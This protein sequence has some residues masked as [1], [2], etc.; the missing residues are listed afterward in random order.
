M[1]SYLLPAKLIGIE[2]KLK[3]TEIDCHISDFKDILK[4]FEVRYDLLQLIT[5]A[6]YCPFL[7]CKKHDLLFDTVQC[8]YLG[9]QLYVVEEQR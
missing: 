3:T 2:S 7:H 8:C 6:S 4:S 5:Y 9:R 1:Y